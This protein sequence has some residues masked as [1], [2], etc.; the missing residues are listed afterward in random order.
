MSFNTE[1]H[2]RSIT[3]TCP[4]CAGTQFEYDEA[5]TSSE[6]P[7]KCAGCERVLTRDELEEA[8]AENISEHLKEFKRD[9]TPDLRKHLRDTLKKSFRGNK[10]F[11]IK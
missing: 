10:N 9:I 3:L 11:R 4:T 1:K 5:E 2:S 8:N 6:A 7:M